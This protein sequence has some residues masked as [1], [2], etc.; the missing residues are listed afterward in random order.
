MFRRVKVVVSGEND[1]IQMEHTTAANNNVHLGTSQI[2]PSP[3]E[4][5][6]VRRRTHS[7]QQEYANTFPLNPNLICMARLVS[8]FCARV[9]RVIVRNNEIG[10]DTYYGYGVCV[11]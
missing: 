10:N 6:G 2:F 3:P 7:A 4:N 9:H 11:G 1:I 5:Y 8:V